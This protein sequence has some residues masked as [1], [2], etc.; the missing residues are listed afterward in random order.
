M[1][2]LIAAPLGAT[3]M[4]ELSL[5]DQ[6]RGAAWIG[7]VSVES[8]ET[9]QVS[10]F[11]FTRIQARVIEILKG[12]GQT[13]QKVSALLPGGKKGNRIVS[14]MGLPVLRTGK[15]Y[16]L[17]LN[18]N[19]QANQAAYAATAGAISN[20]SSIGWGGVYRVAGKG[21][22]QIVFKAGE[23]IVAKRG[24]AGLALTHESR[25]SMSYSVFADSV[26]KELN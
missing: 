22:N 26:F 21:A 14:V 3:T 11:P 15:E 23:S 18:S 1:F 6:A 19:P 13:G 8:V 9:V 5:G 7:K 25:D 24:A 17:F 2:C 10:G 4:V 20:A 12:A 16:V